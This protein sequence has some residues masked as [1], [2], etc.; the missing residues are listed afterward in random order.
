MESGARAGDSKSTRGTRFLREESAVEF[1]RIISF[2]DGVF[3]IAITLLV[4]SL[5]VPQNLTDLTGALKDQIPDLFAFALSFAVLARIWL[6]HHRLFA[7]LRGIDTPLIL[8]NFV[9]LAF[10][11]LVPFTSE[12]IGDYGGESISTVIYACNLGALG[13]AG[14]VMT[15]YAF[16]HD[17]V[18]PEVAADLGVD[19]GPG[20]WLL[21]GVFLLSIPIALIDAGAAQWSWLVL[22]VGG[23]VL[24]RR[25]R[26]GGS[27]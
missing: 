17:L 20:N 10:V 5:S 26:N 27:G 2:S 11:T 13:L 21:A 7:A 3:A 24:L 9:Y 14:G 16:R 12:V 15:V 4:L 23:S 6:F 22:F 1:S 18:R 8:L 25:M 19:L